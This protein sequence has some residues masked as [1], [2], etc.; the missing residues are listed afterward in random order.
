MND[1]PDFGDKF[2]SNFGQPDRYREFTPADRDRLNGRLPDPFLDF[3]QRDGFASFKRQSL[4]LCD[5][6]DMLVAKTAWL[7]DFTRGE[8]FM[9]TAFGDFFFWDGEQ[10]WSCLVH[11]SA[12]MYAAHNITW[13]LAESLSF[14]PF[15]R[16][17]GVPG[18]TDRGRKEQ[19]PL[20][21]DE[22]Y[23]WTPALAVGGHSKTSKIEKGNMAVALDLLS[24]LQPI[25][26]QKMNW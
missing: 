21:S 9:R 17:I 1:Y 20:Q 19:G 13:F 24:Q 5:P 12:I 15:L 26:V 16:S 18:F 25:S 23:I 11:V 14:K 4:W 6:D 3:L 8:I 10:C 2:H 22:V 7:K